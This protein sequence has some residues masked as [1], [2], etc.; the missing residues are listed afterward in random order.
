ME[1]MPW[2]MRS[3]GRV[4]SGSRQASPSRSAKF[5]L[6]DWRKA[7]PTGLSDAK[8]TGPVFRSNRQRRRNALRHRKAGEASRNATRM[9]SF[10]HNTL[11]GGI[12]G[13]HRR[14]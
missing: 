7:R 5:R 12:T 3:T 10:W 1:K 2:P 14:L 4:K 8:F 9:S 13:T 6:F 11:S